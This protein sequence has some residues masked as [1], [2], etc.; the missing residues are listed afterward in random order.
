MPK[1]VLIRGAKMPS[2]R[3]AIKVESELYD[4]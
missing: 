4:K 1:Y 2:K 3:V